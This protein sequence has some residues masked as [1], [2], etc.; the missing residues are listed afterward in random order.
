MPPRGIHVGLRGGD[1]LCLKWQDVCD[2]DGKIRPRITVREKK[3]GNTRHIS[4]HDKTRQTLEIWKMRAGRAVSPMSLVWP[5]KAV[6]HCPFRGFI[7][8][9][10]DGARRPTLVE[11]SELICSAK[12]IGFTCAEWALTR[13]ER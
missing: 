11:T 9:S 6:V 7:S 12:R 1:L 8:W 5:G 10:I 2:E 13:M 3:T 4:L